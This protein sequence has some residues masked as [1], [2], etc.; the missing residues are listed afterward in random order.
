MFL[1]VVLSALAF[2]QWSHDLIVEY[3]LALRSILWLSPCNAGPMGP[4]QAL[5]N[6]EAAALGDP[7]NN[8][9]RYHSG[10]CA[11]FFMHGKAGPEVP[12]EHQGQS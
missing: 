10:G 6:T 2:K 12:S 1:L 7:V 9:H 3:T 11:G 4:S 5:V 8:P